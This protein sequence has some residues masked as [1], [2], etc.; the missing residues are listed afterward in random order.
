MKFGK[1]Q[2]NWAIYHFGIQ[3]IYRK[4]HYDYE[5]T[6]T[7]GTALAAISAVVHLCNQQLTFCGIYAAPWNS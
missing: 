5:E 1:K 6:T 4:H 7:S 2:D 3:H